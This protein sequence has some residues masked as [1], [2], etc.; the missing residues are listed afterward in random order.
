MFDCSEIVLG[1]ARDLKSNLRASRILVTTVGQ[2][3][4][5][6]TELELVNDMFHTGS[7]TH[8][9]EVPEHRE[10]DVEP[11]RDL[12]LLADTTLLGLRA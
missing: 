5:L 11:R 10:Y 12:H 1:L 7:V 8:V 4:A 2:A 6:K 9:R 3:D